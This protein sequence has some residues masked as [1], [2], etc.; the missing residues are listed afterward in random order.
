MRAGNQAGY[1]PDQKGN[2]QERRPDV[3]IQPSAAM[4]C[5]AQNADQKT[6]RD[7][8]GRPS[9][10]AQ[11]A[12]RLLM[13]DFLIAFTFAGARSPRL[14]LPSQKLG[15]ARLGN[16]KHVFSMKLSHASIS[17]FRFASVRSAMAC[18]ES[19]A[20]RTRKPFACTRNSLSGSGMAQI[21]PLVRGGEN[22][23]SRV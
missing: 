4:F 10:A 18:N 6:N 15:L 7:G 1:A 2:R 5:S 21:Y 23:P 3:G 17:S 13:D 9:S 16:R 14:E 20:S 19:E 8:A 12:R 22:H 11:M